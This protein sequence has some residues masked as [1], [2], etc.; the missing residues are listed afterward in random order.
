[1]TENAQLIKRALAQVLTK[2]GSSIQDLETAIAAKDLNK[3]AAPLYDVTKLFGAVPMGANAVAAGT[4]GLGG[5]LGLGGYAAYRGSED[6]DQRI[7]KKLKEKKQYT[8]AATSINN[9]RAN[10]SMF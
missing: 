5:L 1:M 2:Q 8:D 10:P 9:N 3:V 6:S 7:L 4:L